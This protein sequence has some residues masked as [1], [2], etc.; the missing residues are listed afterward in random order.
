MELGLEMGPRLGPLWP[1]LFSITCRGWGF[2]VSLPRH[3]GLICLSQV[4][5]DKPLSFWGRESAVLGPAG[6]CVPA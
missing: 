5:P 4:P 1:P 6:G 2:P 3:W